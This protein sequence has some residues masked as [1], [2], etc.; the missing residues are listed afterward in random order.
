MRMSV[1]I[2]LIG[3]I[4]LIAA[5]A[6]IA[7]STTSGKI[8]TKMLTLEPNEEREIYYDLE[9]G[10]YTLVIQTSEMIEYRLSNSSGIIKEGNTSSQITLFISDLEGNY[11]LNIKNVGNSTAD[12]IV[13]FESESKLMSTGFMVLG[14]GGVCI[15]GIIVIIVGAFLIYKEK[16]EEKRNVY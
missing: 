5:I 1:V 8:E 15:T 12:V 16:K 7:F 3:V 14:S 11:T 9:K 2:L 10:N 6:L 4:L 13:V